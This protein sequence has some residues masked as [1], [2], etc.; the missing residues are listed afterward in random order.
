MKNALKKLLSVI[1][2]GAILTSLA[3]CK[4]SDKILEST[5]EEKT[6]VMTVGEYEVPMEL[7]RYIALNC[8]DDFEKGNDSSIWLGESGSEL[9]GELDEDIRKTVVHL[10]TTIVMCGEYGISPDDSYVTDALDIKMDEIYE[11]YEYDY[12]LYKENI[13]QYYMNDS[14]Y[15]FII[16][17]EILSEEL[18][19]KMMEDGTV[20]SSDEEL[21]AIVAGPEFIRVKQIL[22]SSDNGKTDEEN[23]AEAEMLLEKLNGG[24]DFD[25]LIKQYGEDLYLFNNDDG[26]YI[27]RGSYQQ[28]FEDAAFGLEIGEISG[29]V[30]TG[31]GYSI[32]KRYPKDAVYMAE[33]FDTLADD[34]I[35]GQY[36]MILEKKEASL[37]AVDTDK[38]A[39]YP[40]F[41]LT[42][43]Q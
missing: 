14:V 11:G 22:I 18:I 26:Y 42:M 27:S 2:A 9:L 12:E 3:S 21:E 30:R 32:I 19:H 5:K 23:R 4:S 41:S 24:E 13:A 36:N 17:N 10:Y 28:E 7:Y 37:S 1:C 39:D 20:P 38:M 31:A 16:Q 15:R 8:K 40:V 43:E 35:R 34:Y 6:A 33:N 25:E 29:I